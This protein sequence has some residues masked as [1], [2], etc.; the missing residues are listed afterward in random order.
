MDADFYQRLLDNLYDGVYFLDPERRISFWNRGAERI[1]GFSREEVLGK[2]CAAN[3][4]EHVDSEGRC[5]CAT[6][7]CP[8][9]RSMQDGQLR[10]C[11][12]F[13]HHR[14]GH[15]V[16]VR[17]RTSPLLDADGRAVGAI[18]VF[19]ENEAELAASERIGRLEQLA[20]LDPLT[21]LG[22]RRHCEAQLQ[23]RLDELRRY[24][25][26][27]GVLFIDIDHFKQIND[28]FGH[29]AGD[30]VLRMV[31][32]TLSNGVRSFDSIRLCPVFG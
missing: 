31:G 3:I 23:T 25:W 8:A 7:D 2:R 4:L 10:D 32:R 9:W 20:L 14:A 27:F 5:L 11:Q 21:G 17:I 26:T 18:E 13:L 19:S 24:G 28:E 6:S 30:Q 15:R 22:N 29:E 1:T 16:P 12:A